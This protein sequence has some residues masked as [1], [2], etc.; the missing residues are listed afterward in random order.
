M[1]PYAGSLIYNLAFLVSMTVLSGFLR[2]HRG[3]RLREDLLQGALFG[4]AA[5]IGMMFP[6][7]LGPGLIF[8][9]RSV[10]LSLCG[11]CFGLPA[12][13]VAGAMALMY[14]VLVVGGPGAIVGT[15]V[16]VE[17]ACVGLAFHRWTRKEAAQSTGLLLGLGLLVSG[18]LVLLLF[19]LPG[20]IGLQVIRQIGL[21][22]LATYPLAT[23]LIGKVLSSQ[24]A[25]TRTLEALRQSQAR[26]RESQESFAA[27]FENAVLGI[28]R[29]SGEGRVLMANQAVC[30]M[31]GYASFEDL[32]G[33]GNVFATNPTYP[34]PRFLEEL[35]RQ[36]RFSGFEATWTRPN[37][38]TALLRESA[39][40]VLDASGELLYFEGI[41]EDITE[42]RRTEQSLRDLEAQ[43]Q[44]AQ[45]MESLGILVAGVAHNI[46]N[47]LAIIMGTASFREQ[48]AGEPRDQEAY[49]TIG[50][51]CRRGRDMVKSLMQFARP[52]LS[53][54]APF[55]LHALIREVCGL[56]ASTTSN[57]I[58]IVEAFTDEPLWLSGD[59]GT[60]NHA[61]VN[62]CINAV[63]AMPDGGTLTFRTAVPEPGW[64]EVAVEDNGQG[65]PKEVMVHVLEPFFTT[66]DMGKGT[67]LGLSITY[68][69]IKAHGGTMEI[70]SQVGQG[71]T[72]R[73][74]FPRIP[75]PDLTETASPP[76]PSLGA[77]RICLVD[78]DED[79][80]VLMSRLLHNAGVRQV[81]CFSG[82][83][84]ALDYLGTEALPDLVILDQNMPEMNGAQTMALIRE[85]Y[86]EMP[87]L[88]SSGQP[89]IDE[90]DCFKLPGVE[91]IPKPFNLEEI[92][93]KLAQFAR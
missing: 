9:G 15:L 70:T 5:V 43:L 84:E 37:G 2:Q 64:V 36:S 63:D 10:V 80:R 47:V 74:R 89:D 81:K 46:N 73:L 31:L 49:R 38:E 85:R 28:Y 82:G 33:S 7:V 61:L 65:M 62:L 88:I 13:L 48:S 4:A 71:T 6:L 92:R 72:V 23:L 76:A 19:A 83:R 26:L 24:E 59:A 51:V 27:L 3:P 40:S 79:V 44:Q 16:I 29:T 39:R 56:L 91:V 50:K 77:M 75:A 54:Q 30:A 8:D 21:P 41:I 66:K 67:G 86:P 60:I 12:T 14:R 20:G 58:R 1:I 87:I 17:S 52:T 32:A 93:A 34:R 35:A 11:L 55:E 45:K 53:S 57:R 22:V 78:D 69:V 90:W 42:L 18:I 25:E 68:G